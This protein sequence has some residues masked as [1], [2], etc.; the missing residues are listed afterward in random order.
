ML[1]L[2]NSALFNLNRE[3]DSIRQ[4]IVFLGRKKLSSWASLM[5][6]SSLDDRPSEILHLT[7]VRAK[8]CELLSEAAGLTDPESFFTVGLFSGLDILMERELAGLIK[9]LPLNQD[10]INALLN[11]EGDSGEALKCV[12]A[13]ET[14]DF[15]NIRF[16]NLSNDEIFI[17]NVEAVSLTNMVFDTN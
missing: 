6:L 15:D 5:A 13:Y 14:S 9:P 10:I 4:A 17:T 12:L 7:M 2:I 3:V 11:H 1:K 8:M 16:K